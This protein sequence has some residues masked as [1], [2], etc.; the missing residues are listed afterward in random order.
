MVSAS[1]LT[2]LADRRLVLTVFLTTTAFLAET[3]L[4]LVAFVTTFFGELET[5]LE[6]FLA[7]ILILFLYCSHYRRKSG[8]SQKESQH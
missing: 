1:R 3:F 4:R 5:F 6:F 2:A 8:V 7:G